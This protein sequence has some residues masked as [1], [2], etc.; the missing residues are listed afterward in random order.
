MAQRQEKTQCVAEQRFEARVEAEIA[1]AVARRATCAVFSP[2]WLRDS[3]GDAHVPPRGFRFDQF[4][5]SLEARYWNTQGVGLIFTADDRGAHVDIQYA[6]DRA[7]YARV[8]EENPEVAVLVDTIVQRALTTNTFDVFG[9]H[10]SCAVEAYFYVWGEVNRRLA[11][12]NSATIVYACGG[13]RPPRRDLA[14]LGRRGRPRDLNVLL[15]HQREPGR[16]RHTQTRERELGSLNPLPPKQRFIGHFLPLS[17]RGR[18]RPR[19]GAPRGCPPASRGTCAASRRSRAAAC[20]R[21]PRR[22]P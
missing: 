10:F 3:N 20:R 12:C 17:A 22:W 19:P 18:P 9:D 13:R 6:F 8:A 5:H 2:D 16:L 7:A 11:A 4:Y 21:A 1:Q 15:E 14:L